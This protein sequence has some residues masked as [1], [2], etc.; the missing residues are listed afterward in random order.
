[1]NATPRRPACL[2]GC[3]A[4]SVDPLAFLWALC[5]CLGDARRAPKGDGRSRDRGPPNLRSMSKERVT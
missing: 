5:A 4:V 3:W 2:G 1:M